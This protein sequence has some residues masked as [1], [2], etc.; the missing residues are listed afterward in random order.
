MTADL[1]TRVPALRQPSSRLLSVNTSPP[2]PTSAATGYA[3]GPVRGLRL[4]RDPRLRSAL[5]GHGAARADRHADQSRAGSGRRAVGAPGRR[6]AARA[7]TVR[8]GWR[9]ACSELVEQG[10]GWT[11]TVYGQLSAGAA[12]ARPGDDGETVISRA[13]LALE[14]AGRRAPGTVTVCGTPMDD[15]RAPAGVPGHRPAPGRRGRPA[16]RALPARGR[17]RRRP[18]RRARGA[19]PL[20]RPGARLGLARTRSS[21]PP[22]ATA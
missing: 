12:T 1:T 20:A 19:G 7:R 2:S 13:S 14:D 15:Q 10:S 17:A 4:P 5:R 22:S 8:T 3:V 6:H 18:D 11:S 21:R 9:S 16:H